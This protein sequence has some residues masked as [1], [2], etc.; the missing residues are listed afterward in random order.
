MLPHVEYDRALHIHMYYTTS[1]RHV[2]SGNRLESLLEV[3][4]D[5]LD[6]LNPNRYLSKG[7]QRHLLSLHYCQHVLESNQGLPPTT[8]AH[9]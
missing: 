2:E 3:R 6:V 5:I 7:R 1:P 8:I 4:N 9:Q